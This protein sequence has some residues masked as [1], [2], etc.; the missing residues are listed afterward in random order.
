MGKRKFADE[1]A[2]KSGS[3]HEDEDEYDGPLDS[4]GNIPDL[5]DDASE[6]SEY[7]SELSTPSVAGA[8]RTGRCTRLDQAEEDE[9]N[10]IK[11]LEREAW[12]VRQACREQSALPTADWGRNRKKLNPCERRNQD[13]QQGRTNT[14]SPWEDVLEEH[15]EQLEEQPPQEQLEHPPE[16]HPPEE[17]PPE[18]PIVFQQPERRSFNDKFSLLSSR[19]KSGLV[20]VPL[21]RR[22]QQEQKQQW[23]IGYKKDAKVQPRGQA[24]NQDVARPLTLAD[25]FAVQAKD[26]D[27]SPP[28]PFREPQ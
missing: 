8:R 27:Y 19:M 14:H 7:E 23:P 21:Q 4:N 11:G 22:V 6:E 9:Y 2:E 1:E 15:C 3:D 12:R 20:P 10:E 26:F 13:L 18:E 28:A 25:I 17:Q 5:I 24:Y 16:E